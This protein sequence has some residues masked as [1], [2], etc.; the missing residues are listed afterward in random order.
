MSY[1]IL[2]GQP[3][4]SARQF[5]N[6]LREVLIAEVIAMNGYQSHIANSN[7]EEINNAWHNI[8]L[9]EKSIMDGF[10][11]CFVDMIRNSTN[12]F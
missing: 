5:T 8:M 2:N 11:N 4:G 7:I 12:S 3:Q 6:K 10:C 9:D 1:T